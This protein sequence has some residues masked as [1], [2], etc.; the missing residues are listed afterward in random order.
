[1][2]TDNNWDNRLMK[3]CLSTNPRGR[4]TSFVSENCVMARVFSFRKIAAAKRVAQNIALNYQPCSNS[5][6][7]SALRQTSSIYTYI[8][9]Y[10]YLYSSEAGDCLSVATSPDRHPPTLICKLYNLARL[11]LPKWGDCLCRNSFCLGVACRHKLRPSEGY[12]N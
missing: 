7:L 4:R 8:Y 5:R 11:N 9:I 12:L 3:L 10:V 6:L 2:P 1:M